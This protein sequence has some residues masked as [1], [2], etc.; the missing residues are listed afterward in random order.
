MQEIITN[1]LF[2]YSC[3]QLGFSSG[4]AWDSAYY[5]EGRGD[6]VLKQVGCEGTETNLGR[7][8]LPLGQG[9]FSASCSHAE[10]A[11]VQCFSSGSAPVG[12]FIWPSLYITDYASRARAELHNPL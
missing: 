12:E 3:V 6:I 7:C 1:I 9:D 2:F 5:G 8:P 11:G 4:Q 10:D